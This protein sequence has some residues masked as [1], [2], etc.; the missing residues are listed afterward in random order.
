[1]RIT[2]AVGLAVLAVL[3][4]APLA[5]AQQVQYR[6]LTG[7]EFRAQPDTGGVARAEA[8]LKGDPKNVQL[9]LALGLAQA[10]I[11]QYR[12]AIATFSRGIKIDPTNALLYRW[13]GHRYI[14]TGQVTK[15]LADLE[16]GNRI[17]STN[18][19]IYYHLG[20]AHF[21]RGEFQAAA[22]AFS[23]CQRR[24]PDP[25][26]LAGATDWL[27]MSLSR[28]GRKADAQRALAPISDT[29]KVTTATA[30]WQRL[31]LYR[32]LIKPTEVITA[33]DTADVQVA[34]LSFGVG[35]WYLTRGDMAKAR[36]W[37]EKSVAS[38]GWPGFGFFASQVELA[39]MKKK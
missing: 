18:Y 31:L 28:A 21:L 12:E 14:S 2:T 27:W 5:H 7:V 4:V 6:S 15:A 35:N 25:N 10:A 32:G 33:K 36:E 9:I 39:R 22:A 20:V 26:E 24:A 30:Y 1:M 29:L 23:Q 13:R 16:R 3:A 38:R 11:R 17:D 8:A 19:G 34:T 37:F